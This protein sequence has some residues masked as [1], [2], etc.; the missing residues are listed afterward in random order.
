MAA[1][2]AQSAQRYAQL[3]RQRRAN[4]LVAGAVEAVTANAQLAVVAPGQRIDKRALVQRLVKSGIKHRHRR[5]VGQQLAEN[6]NAQRV[7]RIMQ[8]GQL[9]QALDFR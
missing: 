4:V 7:D 2:H 8:R 5:R 6:F 1:H 3:F 9:R